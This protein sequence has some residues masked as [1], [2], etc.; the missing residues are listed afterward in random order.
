MVWRERERCNYSYLISKLGIMFIVG[1]FIMIRTIQYLKHKDTS[2]S[3][4]VQLDDIILFEQFVNLIN[5]SIIL[6]QLIHLLFPSYTREKF[7]NIVF[8]SIWSALMAVGIFHRAIGGFGIAVVRQ[9]DNLR[10]VLYLC[11]FPFLIQL[12]VAHQGSMH[13]IS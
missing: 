8:G 5:G 2:T 7:G 12:F 10:L 9:V 13:Q 6:I 4:T 11:F 3:N 1:T